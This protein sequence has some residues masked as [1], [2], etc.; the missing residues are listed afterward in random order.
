MRLPLFG[1]DAAAATNSEATASPNSAAATAAAV[2]EQQATDEKFKRLAADIESLRA[3]NQAILDKLSSL[4]DDLK[5]IRADQAHLAASAISRE[6]LKPLAQRIEEV[7][8]KREADRQLVSDEF[9]KTAERLERLLTA[10]VEPVPRAPARPPRTNTVVPPEDGFSYTIKDGDRLPEIVAAYNDDFKSKNMKRIS[11][12]M[13]M[14]AN[15]DV[16]WT[17]LKVGQKIII[18]R[19]PE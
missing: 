9:K 11:L 6:D 7:D 17:H 2:A 4:N 3:A 16:D 1:Q 15:P 14:D 12:R 8:K 13:A 10:G 18:P 19:P 5:Q